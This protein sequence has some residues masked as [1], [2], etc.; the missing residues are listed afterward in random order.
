M[1]KG[2]RKPGVFERKRA[3]ADDKGRWGMMT[4]ESGQ[5][6]QSGGEMSPGTSGTGRG[7]RRR[8]V[9]VAGQLIGHVNALAGSN[10]SRVVLCLF[11]RGRE[12]RGLMTRGGSE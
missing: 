4:I 12:E 6:Q 2:E 9:A 7:Q 5:R 3:A 1:Q 11:G 10:R 8:Q